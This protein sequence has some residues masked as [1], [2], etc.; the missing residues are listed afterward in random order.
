MEWPL[1]VVMIIT[2]NR[3]E[4]LTK[5][6]TALHYNLK[7]PMDRL[8]YVIADDCTPGDYAGQIVQ[9]W[10]DNAFPTNM[11]IG[12]TPKNSGWGAN[13]NNAMLRFRNYPTFFIED[14]YLLNTKLDLMAG[15]ALLKK[16]PH[17]GML[18]Y[19][20]TAGARFTYHQDEVDIKDMHP[21]YWSGEGANGKLTYLEIDPYSPTLYLYSHGPHLKSPAFHSYYGAYPEGY[22][23]GT[24]EEMMAHTVKDMMINDNAPRIAILPDF[25]EMRFTHFG[26]S[27]QLSEHDRGA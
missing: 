11:I 7:Y 3:L 12:S 8:L 13:A 19:R 24:T 17:I 10:E 1:V 20:G 27:Y 14:D 5:T 2:Y 15:V 9:M 26:K 18:R 25:V 22:K 21:E 16:V 23:L 4:E 6:V